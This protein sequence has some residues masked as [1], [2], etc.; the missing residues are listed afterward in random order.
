ME[1]GHL[2]RDTLHLIID[3]LGDLDLRSLAC[4]SRTYYYEVRGWRIWIADETDWTV[5]LHNK[6]T[7]GLKYVIETR[8]DSRDD[9]ILSA[10]NNIEARADFDYDSILLYCMFHLYFGVRKLNWDTECA[11]IPGCRRLDSGWDTYLPRPA[12]LVPYY[13]YEIGDSPQLIIK[14]EKLP[15]VLWWVRFYV[16][17]D[18]RLR[19]SSILYFHT[20]GSFVEIIAPTSASHTDPKY[21]MA[22]LIKRYLCL[23]RDR[24]TWPHHYVKP[25]PV[26]HPRSD[27]LALWQPVIL[28]FLSSSWRNLW[29]SK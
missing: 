5:E 15:D 22:G 16:H 11:I 17:F 19:I 9:S 6:L 24:Y 3:L 13:S 27:F 14:D 23:R 18:S 12:A 21:S 1:I 8:A 29:H 25:R 20:D 10:L 7:A 2:S 4:C 28:N 26:I